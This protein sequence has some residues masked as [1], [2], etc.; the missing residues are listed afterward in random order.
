MAMMAADF[1]SEKNLKG[2][3]SS[4]LAFLR[5]PISLMVHKNEEE[6]EAEKKER[7]KAMIDDRDT[8]RCDCYQYDVESTS[9]NSK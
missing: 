8:V 5:T 2:M 1:H 4:I 9:E 3:S 6:K 7:R